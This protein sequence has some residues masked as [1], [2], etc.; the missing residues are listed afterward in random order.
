MVFNESDSTSNVFVRYNLNELTYKIPNGKSYHK[1]KYSIGYQLYTSYESDVVIAH[2]VFN[3]VDSLYHQ[4]DMELIFDFDLQASFPDN[5]LFEIIIN[6]LNDQSSTS[7]PIDLYKGSPYVAQN[8]SPVNEDGEVLFND[9]IK[10]DT[11]LQLLCYDHN[12]EQLFV[13]HHNENFLIALLPFSLA[14]PPT[15]KYDTKNKFTIQVDNGVSELIELPA[16]G[17]YYFQSDTSTRYGFTIVHPILYTTIFFFLVVIFNSVLI[18][19]DGFLTE[20]K[21]EITF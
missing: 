21:S 10:S 12:L 13:N 5:Y 11:K 8:F 19:S 1:P 7:Y 14:T 20:Q 15:Y 9:W 16:T 2:N 4:Q 18:I 17:L 3:L 6:D